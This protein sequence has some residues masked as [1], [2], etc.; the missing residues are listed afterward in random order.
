MYHV[1]YHVV[2][3]VASTLNLLS[4]TRDRSANTSKNFEIFVLDEAS[5]PIIIIII[6]ARRCI[7]NHRLSQTNTYNHKACSRPLSRLRY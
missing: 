4:E 1:L 7:V 6:T 5:T 2:Q 3:S